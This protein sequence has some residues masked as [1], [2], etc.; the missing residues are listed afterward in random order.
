MIRYF[1]IIFCLFLSPNIY[2]QSIF[3]KKCFIGIN[4]Y[5][6]EILRDSK[7]IVKKNPTGPEGNT[8]LLPYDDTTFLNKYGFFLLSNI[9]KKLK[10]LQSCLYAPIEQVL[11]GSEEAFFSHNQKVL[12]DFIIKRKPQKKIIKYK[13]RLGDRIF[14]VDFEYFQADVYYTIMGQKKL[15]IITE[16]GSYSRIYDLIKVTEIR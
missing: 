3:H 7:P 2:A 5:Y 11:G 16:K 6:I 4:G 8:A 10:N 9:P 14:S 15:T 13:S 12:S 1:S